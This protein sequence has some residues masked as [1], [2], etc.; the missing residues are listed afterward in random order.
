MATTSIIEFA[1]Y[2]LISYASFIMLLTSI[3]KE[4]PTE[5]GYAI[6]RVVFL[7]PG[8]ICSAVLASTGV[9]IQTNTDTTTSIIKNMNDSSTWSTNLTN[10]TNIVLQNPIWITVHFMLFAV[11]L[12]YIIMQVMVVF[13]IDIR[14]KR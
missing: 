9:N 13:G 7:M 11:F 1:V 12:I 5:K 2:G 4:I 10:T 6:M 14:L 3:S 8:L